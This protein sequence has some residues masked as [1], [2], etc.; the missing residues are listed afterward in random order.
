MLFCCSS[1]AAYIKLLPLVLLQVLETE[2]IMPGED[3]SFFTRAVPSTFMFLGIKNETVGSVH[4]LHNAN[5]KIDEGVLPLGAAM[6]ASL[7][8]EYLSRGQEG[9]GSSKGSSSSREEL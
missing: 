5:F 2:P 6:H 9:F 8:M 3:F 7:A 1:A 4:N